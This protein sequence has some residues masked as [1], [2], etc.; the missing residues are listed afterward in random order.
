MNVKKQILSALL[1][2]AALTVSAQEPQGETVYDFKPHW[3]LQVQPVGG[4]YTLGEVDFS[5]LASYNVQAALGYQFNKIVGLRLAVNAWQ[6]KGGIEIDNSDFGLVNFR[7]TWKWNYFAP[8]LDVQFNLSNVVCKYNPKRFFN[9]YAFVGAGLNF[10]SGND[11]AQD[12]EKAL[13]TYLAS[14]PGRAWD[15]NQNMRYLWD[16]SKTCVFGQGG[17]VGDLRLSDALSLILE[18]NANLLSDK[19]NSKRAGNADWY[20][21]ALAGLKINLGKTY[22]ERFIP[23]PVVEPA[24]VVVEP[25]PIVVEQKPEPVVIEPIRRDVFFTINSFEI[26]DIEAQ[27]VKD[28]ADYMKM[29]P[30]S[31]VV[32]TGYADA[33]TGNDR[34]NDRLAAQR[35]DAV[36]TALRNQY[37][38]SPERITYDSKG[39]RVQPFAENNRNRVSICIAE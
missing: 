30:K 20:F 7:Q 16:G 2:L 28:I 3:F 14:A 33:G 21:N 24:P 34:I 39:A 32:I 35:A 10:A 6:S 13:Q 9:L 5:H 23:A 4:Q 26:A 29:Y 36:V 25:A 27:K 38:I 1:L 15:G 17:L 12:A 8:S 31:K 37:G 19:Y 11:E 22:T 18:V